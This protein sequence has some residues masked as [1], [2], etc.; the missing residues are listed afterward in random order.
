MSSATYGDV[1]TLFFNAGN[2]PAVVIGVTYMVYPRANH[3]EIG[4]GADALVAAN[5]LPMVLQPH[6]ARLIS[7]KIPLKHIVD[8][9]EHGTPI[10]DRNNHTLYE[11]Y[12]EVNF[13]ALDSVGI[14]HSSSTGFQIR[15][16]VSS[17]NWAS[18]GH[19]GEYNLVSLLE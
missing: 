1:K 17:S 13:E 4:F 5:T 12:V 6:D 7:L 11:F 19:V 10:V 2:R 15:T 14:S 8:N 16:E 3:D 9:Y 18:F